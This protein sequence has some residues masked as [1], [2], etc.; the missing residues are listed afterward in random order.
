MSPT[1]RKSEKF[2]IIS[3]H[4]RE[5]TTITR[6]CLVVFYCF[7]PKWGVAVGPGTPTGPP[8]L[9]APHPPPRG[10]AAFESVNPPPRGGSPG[11]ATHT[12]HT[13]LSLPQ[14]SHRFA[15]VEAAMKLLKGPPASASSG[16]VPDSTMS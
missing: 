6:R 3:H 11:P 16:K 1:V 7:Q 13:P 4:V 2:T 8:P 15:L 5:D 14:T 10:W 9:P 12:P